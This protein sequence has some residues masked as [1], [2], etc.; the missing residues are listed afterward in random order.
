MAP[1][2]AGACDEV[3]SLLEPLRSA[4]GDFTEAGE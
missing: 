4:A 2:D 3:Y 1:L